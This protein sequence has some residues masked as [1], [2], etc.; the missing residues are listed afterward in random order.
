MDIF[1][2]G[3]SD[4][5]RTYLG[6]LSN[7]IYASIM[8]QLR[9]IFRSFSGHICVILGHFQFIFRSYMRHVCDAFG[10]SLG[11]HFGHSNL[12]FNCSRMNQVVPAGSILCLGSITSTY[13]PPSFF[14]PPPPPPHT[15]PS[16]AGVV[17]CSDRTCRI[18]LRA[19]AKRRPP[20]R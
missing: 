14:L 1:G 16:R 3:F 9:V 12:F 4:V 11:R 10:T 13:P 6:R 7:V 8:C 18:S 20:G 15:S 17:T 5:S 19:R 2:T